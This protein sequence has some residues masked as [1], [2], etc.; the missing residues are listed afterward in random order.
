MGAS[1]CKEEAEKVEVD[2][3]ALNN[4]K[5]I[6]LEIKQSL[7]E[8][9]KIIKILLLG[10]CFPVISVISHNPTHSG[11]ADCGKSTIAKQMRWALCRAFLF[12]KPNSG[13]GLGLF[14]S[15]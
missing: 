6:E 4:H 7:L 3:E 1:V 13:L 8:E 11:S 2:E 5:K 15:V 12:T 10:E 9:R 14:L